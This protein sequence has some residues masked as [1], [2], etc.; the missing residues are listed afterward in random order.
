M[1]NLFKHFILPII[2]FS[3]ALAI[4]VWAVMP[5]WDGVQPAIAMKKENE[6]NLEQRKQIAANLGRLINQYNSRATELS[7]F[8]KAIP[9]GQNIPELLVM[10]EALASE[11]G[12]VFSGVEFKP[13]TSA[14]GAK[15]LAMTIS[16]KGSYTSFKQYIAAMEKSLRL[17]D[18]SRISF[19][20]I[21]P[22]ATQV[23]YN[24]TEFSLLVNA[25]YQ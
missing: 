13:Q 21:A 19:N 24:A 25:Y 14:A 4:T 11:N 1:L 10:L 2:L 12:M 23:N 20:G 9:T 18:V 6:A 5:L 8:E 22:G 7:S 16:L 17:F 3:A 15:V